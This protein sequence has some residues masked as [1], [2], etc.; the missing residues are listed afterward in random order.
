[1]LMPRS[2]QV[3]AGD[4]PGATLCANI[5]SFSSVLYRR[6]RSRPGITSSNTCGALRSTLTVYPR[7][8]KPP[9]ISNGQIHGRRH[10]RKAES[11]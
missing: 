2:I 11:G 7:P 6:R 4:E 8:C 3:N 1:M 10:H 9:F 5:R